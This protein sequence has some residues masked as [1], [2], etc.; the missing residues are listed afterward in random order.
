G[1]R[2]ADL[3]GGD[4]GYD[5]ASG[6]GQRGVS[7]GRGLN[8]I[9]LL[10]RVA[11]KVEEVSGVAERFVVLN[12]GSAAVRVLFSEQMNLPAPGE[13][14]AVTGISSCLADPDGAPLRTLLAVEWE[15]IANG[16]ETTASR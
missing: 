14:I 15:S 2:I 13:F 8:N 9:G 1:M 12:D 11:G 16:P 10:A 4:A 6:R 5:P 3:G 7:V